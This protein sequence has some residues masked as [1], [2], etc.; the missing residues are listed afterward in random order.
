VLEITRI[1]RGR[2]VLVLGIGLGV[3]AAWSWI[4]ASDPKT[5]WLENALVPGL[6]LILFATY[7]RLP[8]SRVSYALFFVFLLLHEIGARWT[9][10]LVPYDEWWRAAFGITFNDWAG[11]E[12]NHFDRLVHFSYGLLFAYPI[13]ELFLRVANVKGFWGYFLPLDLTISTSTVFELFE[14]LAASMAG[15]DVGTAYLGM[16]GDVWDAQ[17]DITCASFGALLAMCITAAI[18]ARYKRD[19]ARDFVKSLEVKRT[20]PLGEDSLAG[21]KAEV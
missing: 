7:R 15:A 4:G 10:S 12:R 11:L 1:P 5:W 16:Q 3:V 2:F 20:K 9:Y 18:N 8:L 14:W 6:L 21:Q 19:F 17:K 13:R